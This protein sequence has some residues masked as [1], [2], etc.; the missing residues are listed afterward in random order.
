MNAAFALFWSRTWNDPLLAMPYKSS[1]NLATGEKLLGLFDEIP[2]DPANDK[3]L[4]DAWGSS[5]GLTG[6]YEFL[7]YE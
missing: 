1:G 3:K 2:N 4:I 6:W 7:P 5:I